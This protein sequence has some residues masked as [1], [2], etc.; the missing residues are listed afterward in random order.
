MIDIYLLLII[1]LWVSV[2]WFMISTMHIIAT[3]KSHLQILNSHGKWVI[4]E[5]RRY[6]TEGESWRFESYSVVAD[7]WKSYDMFSIT[8]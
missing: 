7:L 2:T 5:I 4:S 1:A 3:R 6:S 8:R